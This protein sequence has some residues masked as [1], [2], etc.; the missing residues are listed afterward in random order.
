MR[1]ITSVLMRYLD[2][3]QHLWNSFFLGT[4]RDLRE[5]EP[6]DSFELIDERLFYALVCHPLKIKLPQKHLFRRDVV[7][8]IIVK[9]K[10]DLPEVPLM[11]AE[12]LS[13]GSRRWNRFANCPTDGLTL[14]FIEF[15]Q[16]DKYGFLSSSLVRCDFERDAAGPVNQ[17]ALVELHNVSF[18]LSSRSAKTRL[19]LTA[20]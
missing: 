2:A 16:W 8:S 7:P 18:V 1:D 19:A 5:C 9:P 4:V 14:R 12:K 10:E 6:L 20:D 3:K 17:E 11:L 15:F 13:G